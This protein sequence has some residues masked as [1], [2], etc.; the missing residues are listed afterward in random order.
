MTFDII[1]ENIHEKYDEK[2]NIKRKGRNKKTCSLYYHVILARGLV[3]KIKV[4]RN[5]DRLVIY[6]LQ[7]CDV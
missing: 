1:H 7:Q 5:N 2:Y 4:Q 6:V 3:Y